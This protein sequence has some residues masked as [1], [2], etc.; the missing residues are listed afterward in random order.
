VDIFTFI[1]EVIGVT[2][3]GAL[4]P[5]PL[6]FKNIAEGTKS[7]ARSGLAFA[8]GHTL[9]EFSLVMVLALG[10]LTVVDQPLVK[11][12]VGIVGGTA[13]LIFGVMQIREASSSKP[14]AEATEAAGLKSN[15]LV[16]SVFTGLNPYFVLWWL[17]AGLR[18]IMDSLALAS[19]AGVVIMYVAH[20]WMDYV[21][22]IGVAYLAKRGTKL[23]GRQGFRVVMIIFG[24]VLVGFGLYFVWTAISG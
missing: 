21:W 11:L 10:L 15:L 17:S 5:G 7:G 18:L 6:F 2:A 23:V 13:L 8:V 22:M 19:L 12:V 4:A 24:V 20:V 3:S 9:V 16:G 1:A 14:F